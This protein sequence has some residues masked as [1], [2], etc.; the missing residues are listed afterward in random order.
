[1]GG[2]V[3]KQVDC[4]IHVLDLYHGSGLLSGFPRASTMVL[5]T[6]TAKYKSVP[7]ICWILT[8]DAGFVGWEVGL[9][10]ISILDWCCA[11]KLIQVHLLGGVLDPCCLGVC[12][13]L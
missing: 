13:L 3:V 6:N 11:S 8:G 5:S 2:R 12:V 9:L 7:M 1:M 10:R 4:C